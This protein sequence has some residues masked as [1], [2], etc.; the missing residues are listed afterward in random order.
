MKRLLETSVELEVPFHDVDMLGVV[1]HGHYYKYLE[2]ARTQLLVACG[3][4]AGD[5]MGPR[6]R[7]VVIESRCRYSFPLRYR[8]RMRVTAWV[9]DVA[10]Q[11]KIAYEIY[12]LEAECRSARAYTTLATLDRDNKLLLE[13]PGEIR[14]RLG[15]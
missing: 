2:A 1:W 9:R 8:E 13:T 6:Y 15:A 3:L 5:L 11:I 12:N 4:D 10:H 14:T 7:F